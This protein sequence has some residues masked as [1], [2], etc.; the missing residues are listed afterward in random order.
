MR[1]RCI[2]EY[3]SHLGQPSYSL[4]GVG[5]DFEG[6]HLGSSPDISDSFKQLCA[7]CMCVYVCVCV[8]EREGERGGRG[9]VVVCVCES[10]VCVCVCVREEEDVRQGVTRGD[11]PVPVD[12][13]PDCFSD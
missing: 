1:K 3:L 8:C 6:I 4:P 9:Y 5:K 12:D 13:P 7:S 2:I 11:C 10:S